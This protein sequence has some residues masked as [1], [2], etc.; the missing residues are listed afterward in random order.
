MTHPWNDLPI[1]KPDDQFHLHGDPASQSLHNPDD[2][3]VL[4]TWWHEIDES[5]C[6]AFGLDF[7]FQNQ[8][9]TTVPA[10]RFY[11]FFF[12]E[13]PPVPILR[14]AQ[15]RGKTRRRVK[16]GKTKPINASIPTHQSASLRIANETR[17]PRF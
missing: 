8:R 10:P 9:V 4:T 12:W 16:S 7:G 11:D 2:V 13:K 17:N 14:V 3:R 5:N 1:V 6:S 15:K